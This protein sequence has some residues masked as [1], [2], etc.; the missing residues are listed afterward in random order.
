MEVEEPWQ[1][2]AC[3]MEIA[4]AVRAPDP[5]AYISHFPVHQVSW[6]GPSLGVCLAQGGVAGGVRGSGEVWVSSAHPAVFG[7]CPPRGGRPPWEWLAPRGDLLRRWYGR[8][9][10]A[11]R[12]AGSI[13]RVAPP[14]APV[15][16]RTAPATGCSTMPLSAATASGPPPSTCCPRTCRRTCTA[17]WPRRWAP[18][19]PPARAQGPRGVSILG[20]PGFAGRVVPV[21]CDGSR[22]SGWA[23]PGEVSEEGTVGSLGREAAAGRDGRQKVYAPAR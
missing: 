23:S 9:T 6:R 13:P 21:A 14:P 1:A 15:G 11:P 7:W 20:T 8:H 18:R 5:A 19:S 12:S 22:P 2:L 3:C 10:G 16:P 4:R 17:E